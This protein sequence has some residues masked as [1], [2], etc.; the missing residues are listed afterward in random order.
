MQAR[1]TKNGLREEERRREGRL[2]ALLE[3]IQCRSRGQCGLRDQISRDGRPRAPSNP[4]QP[5]FLTAFWRHCLV[6]LW[7]VG[8]MHRDVPDITYW[9]ASR[10]RSV[11]P[12]TVHVARLPI[13]L[14]VGMIQHP[15]LNDYEPPSTIMNK[16][17]SN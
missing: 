14:G 3:V 8:D 16:P 17:I 6:I 13:A 15:Q 5:G 9:Q 1:L 7:P 11:R 10:L 4:P 2:P 12:T